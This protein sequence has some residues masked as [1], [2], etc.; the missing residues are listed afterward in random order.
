MSDVV[1]GLSGK[2]SSEC[3]VKAEEWDIRSNGYYSPGL[4]GATKERVLV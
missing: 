3:D 1:I 2:T 4:S